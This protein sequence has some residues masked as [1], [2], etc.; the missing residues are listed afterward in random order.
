MKATL[1]NDGPARSSIA[2]WARI[3]KAPDDKPVAWICAALSRQSF[4]VFEWDTVYEFVWA[5]TGKLISGKTIRAAERMEAAVPAVRLE[6]AGDSYRFIPIAS[7]AK[8]A[9][10]LTITTMGDIPKGMLA[11]GMNIRIASGIGQ[12]GDAAN[13]VQAQPNM[14]G[15]WETGE[16]YYANFGALAQSEYDPEIFRMQTPLELDFSAGP[17]IGILLD[18]SNTLKQLTDSQADELI[19]SRG[20]ERI[21]SMTSP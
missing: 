10:R 3:A 6:R 19:A 16:R 4:T 8:T 13:V 17:E 15:A 9:R 11:I 12:P 2:I 5:N 1:I 20:F 21:V 18:S 14:V 7:V